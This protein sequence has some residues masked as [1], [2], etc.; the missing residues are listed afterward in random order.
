MLLL[1]GTVTRDWSFCSLIKCEHQ[2]KLLQE[3]DMI[4]RYILSSLLIP[5]LTIQNFFLCKCSYNPVFL[6]LLVRMQHFWYCC[7]LVIFDDIMFVFLARLK[8]IIVM[9][10]GE[11][12]KMLS[13]Y[14]RIH[15]HIYIYIQ[16]S[17][18]VFIF[19]F[20]LICHSS[21]CKSHR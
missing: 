10:Q 15:T 7:L 21:G 20:S 2:K 4:F 8:E 1:C 12:G 5:Q 6:W 18:S 13:V 19:V 17:L 11:T 14:A 3:P 16:L 9:I